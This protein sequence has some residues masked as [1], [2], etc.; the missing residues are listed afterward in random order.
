MTTFEDS[1]ACRSAIRACSD[2]YDMCTSNLGGSGGGNGFGVTIDV[3]GGGGVTVA[4][5]ATDLG[6]SATSVCSSLSSE[7]CSPLAATNCDS[8]GE[9]S[10]ATSTDRLTAIR[11]SIAV[12]FVATLISR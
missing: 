7:A 2:N 10:A 1:A 4:G 12:V 8:F 9:G 3:P 5:T 6:T 11:I